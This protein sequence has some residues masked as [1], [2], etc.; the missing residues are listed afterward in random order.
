MDPD[1]H[2]VE[3]HH[4]TPHLY[5]VIR[6]VIL[7]LYDTLALELTLII[8]KLHSTSL[9]VLQNEIQSDNLK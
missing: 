8:K 4:I 1:R 5:I 7:C 6:N 9:H 3:T 2:P